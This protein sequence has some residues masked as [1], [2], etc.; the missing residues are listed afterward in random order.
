MGRRRAIHSRRSEGEGELL[1]GAEGLEPSRALLPTDFR[2]R[3]RLSPPLTFCQD[4]GLD[5]PFTMPGFGSGRQ[6]L[7]V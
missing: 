1:V 7:P 5:Y 2:A 3:V 4:L 6:V